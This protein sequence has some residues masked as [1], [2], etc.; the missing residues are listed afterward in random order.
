MPIYLLRRSDNNAPLNSIEKTFASLN[1][2]VG[3][4]VITAS[5]FY[6][7]ISSHIQQK[8]P[9]ALIISF[10]LQVNGLRSPKKLGTT[11]SFPR[12]NYK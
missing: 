4:L 3:C 2:Y 10:P 7:E 5:P 1:G 12:V 6:A 9:V 8:S 11:I